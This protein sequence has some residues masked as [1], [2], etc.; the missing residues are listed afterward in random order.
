MRPRRCGDIRGAHG[1]EEGSRLRPCLEPEV[2]GAHLVRKQR[3]GA[4][5]G[6]TSRWN[7]AAR[8]QRMQGKMILRNIYIYIFICKSAVEEKAADRSLRS[9]TCVW[10]CATTRVYCDL[11]ST[12]TETPGSFSTFG[13]LQSHHALM[14]PFPLFVLHVC[15]E[16]NVAT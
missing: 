6:R 8:I 15:V 5:P 13:N 4:E 10:M 3:R 11:K 16:G 12:E 2:G 1:E 7:K 9:A 14:R